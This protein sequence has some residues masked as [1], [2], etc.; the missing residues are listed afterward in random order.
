MTT[1]NVMMRRLTDYRE[2]IFFTDFVMIF[3]GRWHRAETATI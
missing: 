3:D 1:K 2:R